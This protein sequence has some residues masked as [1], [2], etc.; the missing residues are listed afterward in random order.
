MI[1]SLSIR[2]EIGEDWWWGSFVGARKRK[3]KIRFVNKLLVSIHDDLIGSSDEIGGVLLLVLDC[4]SCCFLSVGGDVDR[5]LPCCCCLATEL[6]ECL[7][8]C[9]LSWAWVDNADFEDE[10]PTPLPFLPDFR[11]CACSLSSLDGI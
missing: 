11:P 10:R 9:E 5:T 8:E 3:I 2:I 7:G 1:P 6:V 4:C